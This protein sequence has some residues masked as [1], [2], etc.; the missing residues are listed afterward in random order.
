MQLKVLSW[1]IWA[2]GDYAKTIEFLKGADADI[3]GLQEV[4]PEDP[5]GDVFAYMTNELGYRGVYAPSKDFQK[6]GHMRQMG[7]AVFSKYPIL[8]NETYVLSQTDPRVA[9]QADIKVGGVKLHVLTT[10][11]VYEG[12]KPSFIQKI[13]V[14]SLLKVSSKAKT[15][16]MGDFNATP[17]MEQMQTMAATM[18]RVG[19]E[20]PTWNQYPDP[21][22]DGPHRSGLIYTIDYIFVSRDIAYHSYEVGSSSASDH[23]PISTII[24]I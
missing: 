11:L 10:H 1:N 9:I 13:Q 3:V 7:V 20:R 15:I 23:L 19:D 6:H 16:L 8:G 17:D 22:E 24:E 18:V 4:V 14:D 5:D 12:L 2:L 21:A